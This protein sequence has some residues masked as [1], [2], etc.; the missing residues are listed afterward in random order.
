MRLV[1]FALGKQGNFHHAQCFLVCRN[2][3]HYIL[4]G[5]FYLL[6]LCLVQLLQL[7]VEPLIGFLK[8]GVVEGY[9][10]AL[11]AVV[12]FERFLCN[13]LWI[14]LCLDVV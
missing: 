10:I 7:R 12:G 9:D 4:I 2:F 8:E 3:L 5:A 11:R 13:H 1:V 6:R 14:K